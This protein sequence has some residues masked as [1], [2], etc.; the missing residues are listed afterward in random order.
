MKHRWPALFTF[1]SIKNGW[2]RWE[3]TPVVQCICVCDG[4]MLVKYLTNAIS[5][6]QLKKLKKENTMRSASASRQPSPK[7][8][9]WIDLFR[10]ASQKLLFARRDIYH[11]KVFGR[12]EQC[13]L[14]AVVPTLHVGWFPNI[15]SLWI[16]VTYYISTLSNKMIL[17]WS[18]GML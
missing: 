1:Y 16:F 12:S 7:P 8:K 17:V 13:K 18:L 10:F 5:I 6:T 2:H 3:C 14:R 9:S 15:S 4:F 11:I